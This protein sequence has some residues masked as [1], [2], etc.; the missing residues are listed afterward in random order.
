MAEIPELP[1]DEGTPAELQLQFPKWGEKYMEALL[2]G[3]RSK[4]G[5]RILD[6]HA[7]MSERLR[8]L[9]YAA[10]VTLASVEHMQYEVMEIEDALHN[11]ELYLNKLEDEHP[12]WCI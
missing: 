5:Q 4:V 12:D 7:V 1:A 10:E 2:E 3:D 9:N 11:L 8:Q 6:A